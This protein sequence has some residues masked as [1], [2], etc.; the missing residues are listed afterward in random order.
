SNVDKP[1]D[2]E[3]YIFTSLSINVSTDKNRTNA[4]EMGLTLNI[5]EVNQILDLL[6][7]KILT[8]KEISGR[9][10]ISSQKI[11]RTIIMMM[12]FDIIDLVMDN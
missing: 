10:D 11:Q 12:K 8:L 5:G 9:L 7:D 3:H 1:L 4:E 6:G 2:K